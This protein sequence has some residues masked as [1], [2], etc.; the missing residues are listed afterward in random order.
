VKSNLR[1]VALEF[2]FWASSVVVLLPL[3]GHLVFERRLAAK[4]DSPEW[5][6][7]WRLYG[8]DG[9]LLD[10]HLNL[11][12]DF[13]LHP[14]AKTNRHWVLRKSVPKGVFLQFQRPAVVIG[15]VG[16]SDQV[17]INDCVI[18][19]TGLAD[20]KQQRGWWW[21][22][23]RAYPMPRSCLETRQSGGDVQIE[24]EVFY[25]GFANMG[26][27]A[28]PMGVGEA[29][30]IQSDVRIIDILRFDIL[31]IYGILAV[32]IGIYYYLFIFL[33]VPERT[34]NGI[35]AL[36]CV[37]TGIFA[38]IVSMMPYHL[39]VD[40]VFPLRLNFLSAA[41]TAVF[42]VWFLYDRFEAFTKYLVYVMAIGSALLW[43]FSLTQS[44]FVDIF[45]TY[46]DWFPFFLV[47]FGVAYVHLAKLWFRKRPAGAWRYFFGC[48]FFIFCCFYDVMVSIRFWNSP[49]IVPYGFVVLI[50]TVSLAMAK[51]YAGALSH[52][53]A[54]VDMRTRELAFA[55]DALKTSEKKQQEL[56][57]FVL[58]E[59]S[60]LAHDIRSP[61]VALSTLMQSFN[62][63]DSDQ[64]NIVQS[65]LSRIKGIADQLLDRNKV[66]K[67]LTNKLA[68]RGPEVSALLLAQ[69]QT[70]ISEQRA[71]LEQTPAIRLKM[72]Q[73][74]DISAV[75]VCM[76]GLELTRIISN[77]LN[78]SI[79]AL[80]G[81]GII[82]VST[83]ARVNYVEVRVVD[84]GVGIPPDVLPS[85][86]IIGFSQGK[87]AGS[88]LGIHHAKKTVEA[89][90]GAFQIYSKLG[91]GT[92]VRLRIPMLPDSRRESEA[93]P[94]EES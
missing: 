86:G 12:A 65:S 35:F 66:L 59:N 42:F 21:G 3:V 56:V 48:T 38:M 69:V 44:R 52:V 55:I 49:Y 71:R 41:F 82:R 70:V 32:A 80:N 51:E 53:E 61:L 27:Y 88:G 84:N 22:M 24:I 33:L 78:N 34:Y 43:T 23:L 46:R 58:A 83:V 68:L 60:H 63:V 14:N 57:E 73:S 87:K 40:G 7:N 75:R 37:S 50:A 17:R 64:K 26:I 94:T 79:E 74:A 8:E 91:K 15:R 6:A 11:P 9:T 67:L 4:L 2:I 76:D 31:W 13:R 20:D 81:E 19:S 10:G 29:S 5:S 18:G 54:Q 36:F 1:A 62:A 90:G 39:S 45:Q 85:V 47:V 30:E 25:W 77:L 28:G 72:V 89:C 16:D 93:C 92:Y